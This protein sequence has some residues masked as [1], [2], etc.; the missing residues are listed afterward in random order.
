VIDMM[1]MWVALAALLGV[2][3]QL[4]PEDGGR[5]SI[6]GRDLRTDAC[7]VALYFV[8]VPALGAAVSA[9][10]WVT[11]LH[12]PA[13]GPVADAPWGLQFGGEVLVAELAAYWVHRL[14]HTMPGLW[15]IHS[16]HHSSEALRWWS[17]FRSHPL[18]TAVSHG[19]PVIVAAACGAGPGV[20]VPYLVVVTVVTVLAHADVSVP[21]RRAAL[22]LVTPAF[23]RSHHELGRET[24]NF[25]LVLPLCDVVF[26]TASFTVGARSFGSASRVPRHDVLAQLA[27]GFG[28][29]RVS[30]T[31]STSE[32]TLAHALVASAT[33]GATRR[34]E[35]IA[36]SPITTDTSVMTRAAVRP[37]GPSRTG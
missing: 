35:S 17:A 31:P 27:W 11:W 13:R 18:D 4:C 6:D 3:E 21:G 7:W 24:T 34:N 9:A 36:A 20:L 29:Q 15:R 16:V 23:H 25:A 32:A 19:V 2:A 12:S 30:A 28:A 8:F 5:R 10:T 1:V 37:A 33:I 26:R 14:Q 22:A